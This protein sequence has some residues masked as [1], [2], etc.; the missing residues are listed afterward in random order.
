[1]VEV[2]DTELPDDFYKSK[3]WN[4]SLLKF[5]G[6]EKQK[7]PA[8]LLEGPIHT[9]VEA[10]LDVVYIYSKFPQ[11]VY[12]SL[13]Q[14]I[15]PMFYPEEYIS[16]IYD[17]LMDAGTKEN[18]PFLMQYA[19]SLLTIRRFFERNKEFYTENFYYEIN[20]TPGEGDASRYEK[21]TMVMQE[22]TKSHVNQIRRMIAE[23][24]E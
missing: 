8:D 4:K 10:M 19:E 13:G 16:K 6:A 17:V 15:D 22:I 11:I 1:M 20:N 2:L 5:Y 18:R 7:L 21:F 24:K 9:L 23:R 12:N 3:G 14:T